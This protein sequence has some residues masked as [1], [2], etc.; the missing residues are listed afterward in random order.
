MS[1]NEFLLLWART[2]VP[3]CIKVELDESG[4]LW[5]AYEE[6]SCSIDIFEE[7]SAL[8]ITCWVEIPMPD[9]ED[10]N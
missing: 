9:K 5:A 6:L 7:S 1:R 4:A 8:T 2:F 3:T 10:Y